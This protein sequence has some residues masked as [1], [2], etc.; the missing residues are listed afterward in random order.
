MVFF[1][2]MTQPGGNDHTI[3][4]AASVVHTVENWQDTHKILLE[5]Y[6]G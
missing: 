1:G 3:A 5:R 2:D 6:S 4:G